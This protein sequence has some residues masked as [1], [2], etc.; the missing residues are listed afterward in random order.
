MGKK[1]KENA[2]KI[3]K[4]EILKCPK[5]KAKLKY[6]YTLSNKV[7]QFTSGKYFRIRNLGYGCIECND[8]ITYF[9][10]TANKMCFKGYT[11]SA[12]IICTI[13]YYKNLKYSREEICNILAGM[14]IEI[15][16]R[17]IDILYKKFLEVISHN[18]EEDIN[19][20]YQKMMDTFGEIRISIDLITIKEKIFV[21]LYDFFTGDRLGLW[22][23]NTV[24]DPK[25][26]ECLKTFIRKDLNITHI[27]TVRQLNNSRF[28]PLIKSLAPKE[29][30][31]FSFTKF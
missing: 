24:D 18:Y 23:F 13:A 12:K 3:Y 14:G 17:N 20:A 4:P 15:S 26:D 19:N 27:A 10:Q 11:Y 31:F 22:T 1:I 7:V 2:V 16:D 5:C 28:V 21:I 9:S 29:T 30:S 25:L 8:G 6:K